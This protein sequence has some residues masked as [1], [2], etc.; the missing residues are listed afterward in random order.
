MSAGAEP[1]DL[2]EP[3][4][5]APL[6]RG[7][8]PHLAVLLKTGDELYAVLAAFYALGAKRRGWL[9]HRA[10]PGEGERDRDRLAA[11]GLDVR[12][13]EAHETLAIVEFDPAEPP[14]ASTAPWEQALDDALARGYTALWYSRFAIGPEEE[15]YRAVLGFERAWDA[16]FRDRPV[17]TLCPYIVGEIG[18]AAALDRLDGIAQHH[19]GVL[20][21]RREGAF[22]IL[23][24]R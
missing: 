9:A 17:V 2:L 18:G 10:L 22:R 21:P 4:L 3:V 16:A 19:E 15:P 7:A 12:G 13:L 1:A 20:V 6:E 8:C 5:S 11:A 24:S 23:G 14:E